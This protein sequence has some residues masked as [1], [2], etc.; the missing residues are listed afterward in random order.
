M[1]NQKRILIITE[2][3]YHLL[4]NALN[5]LRTKCLKENIS[6]I[7]VDELILQVIDSPVKGLSRESMYESR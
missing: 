6:S 7:D 4:I 3:Q 5:D 2:E 1:T